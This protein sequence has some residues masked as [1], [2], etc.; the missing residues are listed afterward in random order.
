MFTTGNQIACACLMA[1]GKP[2]RAVPLA[3]SSRN[4]RAGKLRHYPGA[5]GLAERAHNLES[6]TL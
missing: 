4:I 2:L 3:T 5:D 1:P 6:F